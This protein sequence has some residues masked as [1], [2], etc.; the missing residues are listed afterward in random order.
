[1]NGQTKSMSLHIL[2]L[3]VFAA[4]NLIS[5]GCKAGFEYTAQWQKDGQGP[6][7]FGP[8]RKPFES[9][10]GKAHWV[11]PYRAG[12][13]VWNIRTDTNEWPRIN[14]PMCIYTAR[15]YDT[16]GLWSRR[17]HHFFTFNTIDL[18]QVRPLG[19]APAPLS[20]EVA[21]KDWT[22]CRLDWSSGKASNDISITVSRLT[23]AVLIE[24]SEDLMLFGGRKEA[25][26]FPTDEWLK[27]P[28]KE[29][30]TPYH[31]SYL[32]HG[33]MN[34]RGASGMH[35]PRYYA[36]GDGEGVQI[37]SNPDEMD[38]GTLDKAWILCWFGSDSYFYSTHHPLISNYQYDKKENYYRADCPVLLLFGSSPDSVKQGDEGLEI[39]FAREGKVVMMPL[40]GADLPKAEDTEKWGSKLPDNIVAR[41]N[42]WAE[43]LGR[44]PVSAAETYEYD[45]DSDTVIINEKFKYVDF[46]Q[47]PSKFWAPVPPMFA[48]A[49]KYGFPVEIEGKVV[50]SGM[51]TAIGPIT[52]VE[53]TDSY[54]VRIG[55]L[56]KIVDSTD[57]IGKAGAPE[58]LQQKLNAEVD[59]I[60]DAGHL[61]P[62][63]FMQKAVPGWAQPGY[64][65]WDSP[66]EILYCL[67]RISPL[68][69]ETRRQKVAEYMKTE[70]RKYPPESD[71]QLPF[72]EGAL[73]TRHR[74]YHERTL[75]TRPGQDG[76]LYSAQKEFYKR[77]NFI[78]LENLYYLS[79]YYDFMDEEGLTKAWFDVYKSHKRYLKHQDWATLGW[80]ARD[81]LY[82]STYQNV[83]RMQRKEFPFGGGGVVDTNHAFSGLVGLARMARMLDDGEKYEKIM[84]RL[85]R[86]AALR[87]GLAWYSHYLYDNDLLDTFDQPGVYGDVFVRTDWQGPL[88]DNRQVFTLTQFGPDFTYWTDYEW[89]MN[90][91]TFEGIVPELAV[92][93]K[94][95]A[96]EPTQAYIDFLEDNWPDWNAAYSEMIY[97]HETTY[98]QPDDPYNMFMAKC[99]IEHLPPEKLQKLIDIPWTG[100][101]DIYYLMKLGETIRSYKARQR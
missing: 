46:G 5:A 9:N 1:M 24:S 85:A 16:H 70:R 101:G 27:L 83:T 96:A 39:D 62:W 98:N 8:P 10:H 87:C 60:L 72:D 40:L 77:H 58:E 99:W 53:E 57:S 76:F 41:C 51:L 25:A 91:G 33:K 49:G 15:D 95:Y 13:L 80:Y 35:L 82:T 73:R 29:M 31:F 81:P 22:H 17:L 86:V 65:I 59:K 6:V 66:G 55:G 28:P 23:P 92:L 32:I 74:S 63:P 90:L 19:D 79:A 11:A 7:P 67:Q 68:L 78:P 88:D 26:D 71:Y 45:K 54:T 4:M 42:F 21:G 36:V 93:L 94:K 97:S 100:R 44:F 64:L 56:G 69:D 52:G 38:A 84:G 89:S 30:N 20:Y 43:R 3:I 48:I 37:Y 2:I 75:N 12:D 61:R 47:T 50:D 18:G 14:M 34:I